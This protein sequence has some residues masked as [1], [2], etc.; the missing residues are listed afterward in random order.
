MH[1]LSLI[2]YPL[3]SFPVQEIQSTS[4]QEHSMIAVFPQAVIFMLCHILWKYLHHLN[5]CL[6][7]WR[8]LAASLDS[9]ILFLFFYTCA[10]SVV[11]VECDIQLFT[12]EKEQHSLQLLPI[13]CGH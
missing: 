12:D 6:Q 7:C 13:N 8:V 2:L 3:S 4:P 1:F 5:T 9:E 11:I 10:V